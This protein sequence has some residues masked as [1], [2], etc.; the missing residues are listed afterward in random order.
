M[1]ALGFSSHPINTPA[2]CFT[3]KKKKKKVLWGTTE[4]LSVKYSVAGTVAVLFD[5][6]SGNIIIKGNTTELA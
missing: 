1:R 6:L 5:M 4:S 3:P 2:Y